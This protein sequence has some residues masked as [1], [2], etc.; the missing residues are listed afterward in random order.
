MRIIITGGSGFIGR[1]LVKD[2]KN[3]HRLHLFGRQQELSHQNQNNVSYHQTDYS[4]N[5]LE[6]LFQTINPDAVI[7]LAALRYSSELNH[8]EYLANL[9]ISL[10]LFETCHKFDV[11]NIVNISTISVYSELDE[12]PWKENS[13]THPSNG[14][15]LSKKWVE[16]AAD[17]FCTKGL[18]IKSLRLAQLIGLGER[19]GYVLQ[20]FLNN[21]INNKPQHVYGNNI[22][23]RQYIY[24][25]DVLTAINH[26]LNLSSI[27]GIF[28]I[29]MKNNYTFLEVAETINDVFEN[30][31]K[32]KKLEDKSADEK[33]YLMDISKAE[34]I[35]EWYPS[36]NLY[37]TYV[38]IKNNELIPPDSK[39]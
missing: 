36:Y 25:K 23:R 21:A 11:Q 6:N 28:N 9:S 34:N 17:Y 30:S 33:I 8:T 22:G 3:F 37:E 14:Y 35:L 10:N 2:L 7:H 15:G 24:I 39:G 1:Y 18:Q 19:D 32:I 12:I 4:L 16:V 5:S 27:H 31:S 26:A 38:D 13:E 20:T 29:G